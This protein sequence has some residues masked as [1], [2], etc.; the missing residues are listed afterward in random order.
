[1]LL[2]FDEESPSEGSVGPSGWAAETRRGAR[3]KKT[4]RDRSNPLS[5]PHGVVLALEMAESSSV[6]DPRR[7]PEAPCTS[8]TCS[9]S[10]R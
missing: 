5:S 7:G 3:M 4:K 2:S 8:C 1:M 6:D 9:L 10:S